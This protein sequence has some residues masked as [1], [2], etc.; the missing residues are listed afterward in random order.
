[1][2]TMHY[3]KSP[4]SNSTINPIRSILVKLVYKT[5]LPLSSLNPALLIMLNI[6][7]YGLGLYYR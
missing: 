7:V 2:Y 1:M 4:I 6:E 3:S 5:I